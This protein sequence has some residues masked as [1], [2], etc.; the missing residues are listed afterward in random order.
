MITQGNDGIL[1]LSFNE[2]EKHYNT[3][4]NTEENIQKVK[5]KIYELFDKYLIFKLLIF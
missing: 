5:S 4:S 2:K 3:M 1:L